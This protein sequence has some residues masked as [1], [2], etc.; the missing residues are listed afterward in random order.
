MVPRTDKE[1]ASA[2]AKQSQDMWFQDH[3]QNLSSHLPNYVLLGCLCSLW[4]CAF[5]NSDSSALVVHHVTF[6][7]G[8]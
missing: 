2:I 6:R 3:L 7:A 8:S 4:L 5:Y 1:I